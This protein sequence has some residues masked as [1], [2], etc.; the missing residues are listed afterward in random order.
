MGKKGGSLTEYRKIGGVWM[1]GG[2]I[3]EFLA[4]RE[5]ESSMGEI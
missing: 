5:V 4:V 1:V 3:W 2:G